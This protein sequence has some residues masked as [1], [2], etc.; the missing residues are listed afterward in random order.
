[1]NGTNEQIYNEKGYM[2]NA[3]LKYAQKGWMIFPIHSIKDGRCSCGKL[4]CSSAGKHPRTING[5]KDATI[6]ISIIREW[7]KQ[8]PDANIGVVTGE[9]SGIIAVDIDPRHMG[10]ISIEKVENR[11]G[12]IPNTIESNTGGGGSHKLLKYPSGYDIRCSTKLA[13]LVGLDVRANAGY[14]VAPPSNHISG[15]SYE[16]A[17]GHSPDDID[18]ADVPA[19]LLKMMLNPRDPFDPPTQTSPLTILYGG[20]PQSHNTSNQNPKGW[21]YHA[22][23]DLSDGNRNETFCRIAG[24][25]NRDGWTDAEIIE[26]LKPHAVQIRFPIDELEAEVIGIC[27]RYPAAVNV[28][29][30]GFDLDNIEYPEIIHLHD[31]PEPPPQEWLVEHVLPEGHI[32]LIHADGGNAKSLIA[33]WLAACVARG[34]PFVDLPTKATNVL[35]CDWELYSYDHLRRAYD[36]ARGMELEAPAKRVFYATM[37]HPIRIM[38]NWLRDVIRTNDIGLLIFDSLG[39][40][41][42]FDQENAAKIAEL[43]M[44][45]RNIQTTILIIDHQAKL[46]D[47]QNYKN[48]KPFG[49]TYKFNL[50]RSVFQLQ[51]S[52]MNDPHVMVSMR[53]TKS[54]FGKGLDEINIEITFADKSIGIRRATLSP[55]SFLWKES[56]TSEKVI[57]ALSHI[58]A[59]TKKEVAAEIDCNE[60]TTGN[61]LADLIRQGKVIT[62]SKKRNAPLYELTLSQSKAVD[63]C[64]EEWREDVAA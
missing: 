42:G 45:L 29:R 8:W 18:L 41:T 28:S 15:R 54:N 22:L 1:M 47:G 7:W 20:A 26:L 58:G 48:K 60:G 21:I 14:I 38:V 36:I 30:T 24:R 19:W 39:V 6:D 35:Y 40:A 44:S 57:H 10:H 43:F 11:Y 37:I 4:D 27:R 50:A 23:K 46:Q 3:A 17:I 13:G 62:R 2:L 34:V 5:L 51:K 32:G 16:W 31:Q 9:V 56:G 33:M 61:V 25:L 55:E 64:A 53:Q 63:I 59:M 12:K 49:S 52:G